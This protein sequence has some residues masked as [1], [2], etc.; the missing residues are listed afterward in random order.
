M[1]ATGIVLVGLAALAVL[2]VSWN[3]VSEK[4]SHELAGVAFQRIFGALAPPPKLKMSWSYAYPA[5]EISFGSKA[6]M[7]AAAQL[8][9]EFRSELD[10]LLRGHGPV[11]RRFRA[12]LGVSFT[13]PGYLA[14]L[15]AAYRQKKPGAKT[16]PNLL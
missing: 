2:I 10:K 16:G 13:Y 11:G 12:E 3:R 15:A 5:F 1:N 9:A 8:N 7:E 14:E 6:E 4:S